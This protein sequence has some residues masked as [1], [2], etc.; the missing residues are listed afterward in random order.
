MPSLPRLPRILKHKNFFLDLFCAGPEL[1]L[2]PTRPSFDDPVR[3]RSGIAASF[4]LARPSA[5]SL[6][7][8]LPDNA[9]N[10]VSFLS[11]PGDFLMNARLKLVEPCNE[12]RQVEA[13]QARDMPIRPA[14]A[15]L[16]SREYL[17]PAEI[18]K[19]IKA[20]KDGRWPLRDATLIIA[21]YRHGLRAVEACQLEWSQVEFGRN[22][23]LHVRRAKQG[24]PSVHP[25]RGGRAA[26]ADGV[27]QGI[28][29]Q[30]LRVHH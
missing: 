7:H 16:R 24:K 22:A 15:E 8:D 5:P 13:N 28:P 12:N 21:A 6:R 11:E 27:A 2:L 26:H 14:N 19:L 20:A 29:G 17:T 1:G 4:S 30:R 10:W 9:Y 25:I 18:E 3:R 23:A